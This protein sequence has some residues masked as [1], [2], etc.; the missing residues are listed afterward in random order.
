MPPI[1]QRELQLLAFSGG[2]NIS[3]CLARSCLKSNYDVH[4]IIY[5]KDPHLF[6]VREGH[7]IPVPGFC[8]SQYSLHV[9][10]KDVDIIKQ[11]NLA[12]N[13]VLGLLFT[14]LCNIL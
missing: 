4:V 3:Q 6:V 11:A 14:V 10:N 13:V 2:I 5:V 9:L 8:V 12:F 7:H 1:S